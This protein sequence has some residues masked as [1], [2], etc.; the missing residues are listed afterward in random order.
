MSIH[1]WSNAQISQ[2]P[3]PTH[4]LSAY[5]EGLIGLPSKPVPKNIDPV[6]S[7]IAL[8]TDDPVLKVV[9]LYEK[10]VISRWWTEQKQEPSVTWLGNLV[11]KWMGWGNY[12]PATEKTTT[13][14]RALFENDDEKLS[15]DCLKTY[16]LISDANISTSFEDLKFPNQSCQLLNAV[17]YRAVIFRDVDPAPTNEADKICQ[18]DACIKNRF[19]ACLPNCL[20]CENATEAE[21]SEFYNGSFA[22]LYFSNCKYIP[23]YRWNVEIYSSVPKAN[24][25]QSHRVLNLSLDIFKQC[26]DEVFPKASSLNLG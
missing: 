17:D 21:R 22:I 5:K 3:P 24:I 11:D 13:L 18:F 2:N 7:Q 20:P 12:A 14:T 25:W 9:S 4:L 8:H 1:A 16:R 15:D 10:G 26:E 23:G 6:S 19:T